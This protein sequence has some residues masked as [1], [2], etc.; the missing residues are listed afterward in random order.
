MSSTNLQL[1]DDMARQLAAITSVDEAKK[2]RDEAEAFRHYAKVSRKALADQNH[3]ARIKFLAERRAGE[4]LLEMPRDTSPG[5][6]RGKKK[7]PSVLQKPF[8]AQLRTLRI[9][10]DTAYRW[11]DL[12]RFPEWK[13]TALFTQAEKQRAELTS[14]VVYDAVRQWLEK[15]K[16]P[17]VRTPPEALPEDAE[18]VLKRIGLELEDL[19]GLSTTQ[20][21]VL[22]EEVRQ[23]YYDLCDEA[24][25]RDRRRGA[26]E[27]DVLVDWRCIGNWTQDVIRDMKAGT[28]GHAQIRDHI[29]IDERLKRS[30]AAMRRQRGER[31][32]PLPPL[33]GGRWRIQYQT[34]SQRYYLAAR[35]FM[36]AVRTLTEPYGLLREDALHP[37][38]HT[39]VREMGV[40]VRE[41]LD[42]L[43]VKMQEREQTQKRKSTKR[44][45][46]ER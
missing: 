4:L 14:T 43:D 25:P 40:K 46:K 36:D 10:T 35:R 23:A 1:L 31:T 12:A 37:L 16:P 9:S 8:T 13:L 21:R 22:V 38:A 44:K 42:A 39:T 11:Q 15:P 32:E 26:E 17:K 28:K 27:P 41:A 20:Q 24:Q 2:L 5:P 19:E 7:K 3:C 29:R 34:P 45:K 30:V 6:G 33:P 18:D